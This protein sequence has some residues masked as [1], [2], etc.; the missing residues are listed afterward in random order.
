MKVGDICSRNVSWVSRGVRVLDAARRMRTEHV[1]DLVVI[2][3]KDG[4]PTPVG[5]FTDRDVVVG[6]LAEDGE[7]ISALQVGDVIRD[8]VPVVTA[9][10][11]EDLA[12]V[13]KRMRSFSVRRVPVVDDKGALVGILSI[14]DAI[15]ALADE[16]AQVASLV[17]HQAQRE[18]QR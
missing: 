17:S 11:D 7:F 13:L 5:V 10:E 8:D 2:D 3:E 1:G 14:D 15:A 6:I 16:F 12:D 9:T 4:R 18:A